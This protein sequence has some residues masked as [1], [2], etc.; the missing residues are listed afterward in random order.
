MQVLKD[1]DFFIFGNFDT[2]MFLKN[3]QIWKTFKMFCDLA[4]RTEQVSN[5][6]N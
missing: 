4:K 3:K 6:Q 1:L 5:N 2:V